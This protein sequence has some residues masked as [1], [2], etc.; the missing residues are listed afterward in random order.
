MGMK[1]F[2]LPFFVILPVLKLWS[3][4]LRRMISWCVVVA[5]V[6]MRRGVC[7]GVV[8]GKVICLCFRFQKLL[9]P[10]KSTDF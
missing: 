7:S 8:L 5:E 2:V 9:F 3:I 6:N 4:E 10:K 1:S